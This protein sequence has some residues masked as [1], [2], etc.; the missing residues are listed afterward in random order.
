MVNKILIIVLESFKRN[1][2]A[3]LAMLARLITALALK[4]AI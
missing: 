1:M 4:L 3:A 2:H